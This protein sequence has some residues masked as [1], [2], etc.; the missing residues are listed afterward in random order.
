MKSFISKSLLLFALVLCDG[1]DQQ[2]SSKKITDPP[3]GRAEETW[4]FWDSFNRAASSGIGAGDLKRE[5][6]SEIV[7][8]IVICGLLED[9]IAGEQARGRAITS[10]AVLHVDPDLTAYAVAFAESR[11]NLVT[12]L[13]DYVA[14]LKKQE[15]MTSGPTLGIGLLSN[16]LN[17]SEET[18][19]GILWRAMLDQ[20]KQTTSDLRSLKGPAAEVERKFV[21]V[22]NASS[23]LNADELALRAKL[24]QRFGRE[25]PPLSTYVKAA[26]TVR[27]KPSQ[28]T[29]QQI[30]QTLMARK[31][32][33][34]LTPGRLR[35]RKNLFR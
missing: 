17:H 8:P 27:P 3:P 21:A 4:K 30:V 15:E 25:F 33:A 14:L 16:L 20:A 31:W 7:E 13:Q 10:L 29:Q 24:S 22:R 18:E 2:Q 5:D 35:T 11:A 6:M 34:S 28:I 23:H 32:E 1:C 19:D 12:A 26:E 9:V